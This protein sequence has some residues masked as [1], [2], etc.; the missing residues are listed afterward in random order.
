MIKEIYEM[1]NL[2][3]LPLDKR[4]IEAHYEGSIDKTGL[5]A[6]FDWEL[7]RESNKTEWVIFEHDGPGCIVNFVQ[8]RFI[9]S[10]EVIF[11]FYFDGEKTPGFE[12]KPQEFGEKYPFLKPLASKYISRLKNAIR[13]V[14][15][16][17]PMPFAKSCKITSSLPLCG[18]WIPNGGWGHVIYHTYSEDKQT[19]T[20]DPENRDYCKLMDM[21]LKSGSKPIRGKSEKYHSGFILNPNE[22]R[23]VFSDNKAGLVTAIRF[24]TNG[25]KRKIL[26]NLKIYAKWDNRE[27]YDVDTN[28]GALFGNE[29]G[30]NKTEYMLSGV[31]T[32]GNYYCFYPMPY[33]ENAEI[34]IENSSD[35]PVEFINAS[36]DISREYNDLYKN[37]RF[38][39]FSSSKYYERKCTHGS[40][41]II[42]EV[43]GSGHIISSTVTAYGIETEEEKGDNRYAC[44]EGDVRIHFNGIRTPQIESDGSE[45]Y[46]C[47]G[48]GFEAPPQCNPT[49]GYDGYTSPLRGSEM[50]SM[51]R[52]LMGDWYTY[53]SG[54]RFGIESGGSNDLDMEH[55]GA[56]F[57]Y[58]TGDSI[59]YE[60]ARIEI[61]NKESE[62][63]VGYKRLDNAKLIEETS[64]FEGDD[65]DKEVTYSGYY[66]GKGSSF[67]IK[68]EPETEH[69][70][71]RRISNQKNFRQLARV[72]VNGAEVTEYQWYFPDCNPYK[73]WLEDEF[74]IPSKY[75]V[76]K[77]S[78]E[79]KIVPQPCITENA[80]KRESETYFNEFGYMIL[81]VKK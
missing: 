26:K 33:I 81:G 17:V 9:E 12:I 80:N 56:V 2:Q 66:G 32:D 77:K 38:G 73:S 68:P 3:Y 75:V 44:C 45:S 71:L 50:W 59:E 55:S 70:I 22:K 60:I 20:F 11:R 29:L 67:T 72:Y 4:N 16:F 15:S 40:D 18:G 31:D 76:N 36:V 74:I 53:R 61:G 30:L 28:F 24:N 19:E 78:L 64:F 23:T 39:Y 5:N 14:R 48:W 65:D 57:F 8:H 79:I 51:N 69:I 49:S 6:D 42:A 58:N 1:C 46:A 13:V 35:K 52:H 27:K 7:Y 21:W 25:F 63:A 37:N 10:N 62:N 41:S 54:F 34:I 43:K 47:Y